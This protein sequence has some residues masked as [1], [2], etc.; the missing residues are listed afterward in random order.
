M[1]NNDRSPRPTCRVQQSGGFLS[2]LYRTVPGRVLL[3]LLTA[4]WV[5]KTAGFVLDRGISRCAIPSFIKKNHIDLSLYLPETY[6]S[7]NACFTRRI[8]PECRPIDPDPDCLISPC[9]AK[10][11]VY[12]VT[13]DSVF[14]IK[15]APYA[16]ADLIGDPN[17]AARFAGGT[18]LIF[19]LTV[20][21]YHR[22][23][24][25]FD[26]Q[27]TSSRFI[28]GVL[29]TVQPIALERYNFYKRNCRCC[30]TIQTERFG[31]AVMTEVG[32]LMVGRIVNHKQSG[33]VARGEEKGYF[34]F[35]GSTI[36]LLLQPGAACLDA[37][38]TDNT[39]AG[40]ETVVRCGET[41]GR[42]SR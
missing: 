9:D 18:C 23:I 1:T 42:C 4:R 24:Y 27:Q 3:K 41:I 39:T 5:S 34:C 37:E 28:P 40:A 10:L 35:G 11:S 32:A 15:G 12:P 2:F 19:R 30:A 17:A 36:V 6:K 33:P 20:D 7:Y 16:V 29:H 21:D 38:L 25:P 8:R 14:M 13:Q 22:Y 26:G 31:T